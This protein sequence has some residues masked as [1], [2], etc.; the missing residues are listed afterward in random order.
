MGQVRGE[1]RAGLRLRADLPST[2]QVD[3]LGWAAGVAVESFGLRIGL[4]TSA[5]EAIAL[6]AGRLPP[7]RPLAAG[8]VDLL[9]SLA[10]GGPGPRPG[11]RH[12]HRLYC[13]EARI[14]RSL[15]L[16]KVLDTLESH[17]R[18]LVAARSRRGVFLHAGAVA[19]RGRALV[20][21][22][23]SRSGKTTLVAELVRAGAAYLSDEFAVIRGDRVEPYPKPLSVR[24]PHEE[25]RQRPVGVSALGGWQQR[26]PVPV[27]LVVLAEF[28]RGAAWRVQALPPGRAMLLLLKHAVP[29]RI[30]PRETLAALEGLVR[31]APVVRVKRGSAREAARRILVWMERTA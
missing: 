19:W 13:G 24:D 8:R 1:S 25:D 9:Y 20:L 11:M 15:D 5:P 18:L 14:A 17:A 26:R 2:R 22:G 16:E 10:L 29:A 3:R 7:G 28:E 6:A 23:G 12:S 4:R 21:P 31:S 30:A 27:G